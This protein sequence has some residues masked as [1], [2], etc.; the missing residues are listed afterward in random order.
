MLI[1]IKDQVGFIS[2]MI[3]HIHIN[4]HNTSHQQNEEYII[5]LS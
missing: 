2:G 5:N 3:Q 1:N 4:K